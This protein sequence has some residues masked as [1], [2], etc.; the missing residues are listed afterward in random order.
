MT[1]FLFSFCIKVK[2][3]NSS[4]SIVI[5]LQIL[6]FVFHPDSE[7]VCLGCHGAFRYLSLC[8]HC[9]QLLTCDGHTSLWNEFWTEQECDSGPPRHSW[10]VSTRPF[11]GSLSR[12]TI[13]ATSF[14][15]NSCMHSNSN[16]RVSSVIL[17][18]QLGTFLQRRPTDQFWI[19]FHRISR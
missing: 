9:R 16:L 8:G 6:F 11:L 10:H 17:F 2:A 13:D 3:L 19:V 7:K 14:G 15:S 5:S 18:S 1:I 12:S 4:N